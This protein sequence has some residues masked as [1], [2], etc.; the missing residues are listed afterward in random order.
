MGKT[1]PIAFNL[2]S[3]DLPGQ[4]PP[5]AGLWH[6]LGRFELRFLWRL[7]WICGL[8]RALLN[9]LSVSGNIFFWKSTIFICAR[10]CLLAQIQN[11][12]SLDFN[13][14]YST[15]AT[16]FQL[17]LGVQPPGPTTEIHM[18]RIDHRCLVY[19]QGHQCHGHGDHRVMGHLQCLHDRR[20]LNG[21]TRGAGE[22]GGMR[23]GMGICF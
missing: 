16:S 6:H 20:V 4:H 1:I 10:S 15:K 19:H 14:C 2:C 21:N 8:A 22:L 5:L 12:Q 9:S 17:A 7:M 13:G 23:C 3:L 18:H 11:M